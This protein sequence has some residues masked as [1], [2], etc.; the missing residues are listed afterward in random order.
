MD[1]RQQLLHAGEFFLPAQERVELHLD[2]ISVHIL[3]KVEEVSFDLQ[4]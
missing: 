2:L 4:R 3:V 1:L